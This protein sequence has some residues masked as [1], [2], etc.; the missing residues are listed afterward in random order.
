MKAMGHIIVYAAGDNQFSPPPGYAWTETLTE[1]I[2]VMDGAVAVICDTTGQPIFDS[3][4]FTL[5]E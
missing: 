5:V 4:T 3:V 2:Y 1:G